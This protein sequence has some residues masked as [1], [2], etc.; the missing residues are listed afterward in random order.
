MTIS[1]EKTGLDR[2]QFYIDGVWTDPVGTESVRTYEAA[3]G[4]LLGTAAL[5]SSADIDHAVRAA[6]AALDHGPWGRTTA[7]E[8]AEAMFRYAKALR[9]RAET[10]S[11]LVSRE[12]GMPITL[13]KPFNGEAPAALLE[14]YANMV[15]V[16]PLERVQP[17]PLGSTIVRRE[18]VGVVGAITPWN[19]PMSVALMKIAPA[20]AAGCTVVLKHAPDTALDPYLLADAATEAG[21]PPGVINI[22]LGDR[23]TGAALV[24]HPGIDKIAF[25]GST[26]A[27]RLIGAECGRL[28]RRCSLELGGKSAAIFCEDG[29]IGTLLA[30]LGGSSFMNNG[31]T[32]TA[33]MR[34]LA[35]RSRYKEVVDAVAA[36]SEG[37]KVGDPLDQS[38][39]CGPMATEHH[40]RRV[41]GYIDDARS[42]SGARLVTGGGRPKGLDQGYFVAP[43]VFADVDPDDRLS[44]EEVFGPVMGITPYDS[45]DQ[46]V[47]LANDSNFGLGGSVWTQDEDKGLDMARRIRAGN[48]GVN[49]W[50][51]DMDAP[52]GG[53]KDSG[54]GRELGPQGLEH[55]FEWKSI[56][57]SADQL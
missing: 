27:G 8:R 38:T 19:F 2:L 37:L 33:Q 6:R 15:L 10:A 23:D 54:I 55:Y 50:V 13:S 31:Q 16:D 22:V 35:P 41:M 26:A 14:M 11:R 46:A 43:T 3:T 24:S 9:S 56:Y 52:F 29:D 7:A 53:Y 34:L 49:Y 39:E 30:G 25:T 44:R 5:G 17:S 12:N 20:L 4:E 42:N 45:E 51:L 32:C 1:A 57:A 28:V 21:L 48:I 47:E 36:H 40:L 18:P